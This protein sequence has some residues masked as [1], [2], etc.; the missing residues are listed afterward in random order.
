[1]KALNAGRS[2][3]K[4]IPSK[5]V[6][7]KFSTTDD[8][9]R[10]RDMDAIIIGVLTPLTRYR[11]PDLS[12]IVKTGGEIAPVVPNPAPIRVHA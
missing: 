2:C 5:R 3:I 10:S 11:A 7:K 9:A 1:M 4:H 12:F 6:A 8:F